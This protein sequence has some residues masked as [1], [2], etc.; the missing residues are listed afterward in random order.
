M[1]LDWLCYSKQQDLFLN[2]KNMDSSYFHLL[3]R[4]YNFMST[5][6]IHSLCYPLTLNAAVFVKCYV[7]INPRFERTISRVIHKEFGKKKCISTVNCLIQ[8]QTVT[9][10]GERIYSFTHY[11]TSVLDKGE[12]STSRSGIYPR[13]PLILRLGGPHK[14]S[15]SDDESILTEASRIG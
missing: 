4:I 14:R 7:G 1:D 8:D 12:Q 3:C 6:Q 11:F 10:Y 13:C 2:N 9:A 5:H 15:G